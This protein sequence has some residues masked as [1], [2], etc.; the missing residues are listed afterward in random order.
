MA[1]RPGL[2]KSVPSACRPFTVMCT[3]AMYTHGIKQLAIKAS[4]ATMPI[5]WEYFMNKQYFSIDYHGQI[6][7]ACGLQVMLFMVSGYF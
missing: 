7:A 6:Y 2:P 1:K 5:S 3:D 4:T